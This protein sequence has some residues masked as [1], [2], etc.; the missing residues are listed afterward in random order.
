MH[1]AMGR[2]HCIF[3]FAGM[4]TILTFMGKLELI[5]TNFV[6]PRWILSEENETKTFNFVIRIFSVISTH[7]MYGGGGGVMEFGI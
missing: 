5:S 1:N 3:A 2:K 7:Y 4:K 6:N